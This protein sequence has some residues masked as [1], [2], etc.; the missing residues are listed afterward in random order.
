MTKIIKK[1][2]RTSTVTLAILLTIIGI[3]AV[4]ARTPEFQSYITRQFTGYLSDR[5]GT[6]ISVGKVSYSY[7]NK[8]NIYDVLIEDQNQDTLLSVEHISLR[9][10]ELKPS[11]RQFRFSVA[12]IY[13][14][15][16]RLITDTT[17]MLNLRWYLNLVKSDKERDTTKNILFS[18]PSASLY[19]GS[20]QLINKTDT[21][22]HPAGSVAFNNMKVKGI[23]GSVKE[24]TVRPDSVYFSLIG[25]ILSETTGLEV[26]DADMNVTIRNQD[27]IFRNVR[28]VSESSIINSPQ[29]ALLP[30]DSI[31]FSDFI[32]KVKLDVHLDR[33]LLGTSDLALF[34]PLFRSLDESFYIAGNFSGTV[35]ELNGR[36]VDLEYR[37]STKLRCDFD[38]SGLPVIDNTFA[39]IEVSE[40]RTTADEIE[41]IKIKGK[42]DIAIPKAVHDMGKISFGGNF[43]GFNTDFVA[44]GTIR[45]E[46]GNFSTDISFRPDTTNTFHFEGLLKAR[47]VDMA[48]ITGNPKQPGKLWLHADMDGYSTSLKHF[49]A[50]INGAIDSV[51]FNDYI[52]RNITLQGKVTEKKWDGKVVVDD[53]NIKM[54][55]LGSFD[56]TGLLPKFNFTLDL[57]NSDLY[58]LHLIKGDTLFK[59]SALLTASFEGNNIDNLDGEMRLIK[60]N[61]INSTGEIAIDSLVISSTVEKGVPLITLNSDIIDAEIRGPHNYASISSAIKAELS[62]LFPSKYK[63]PSSK[64]EL[65]K[66]NFAFKVTFE[67]INR[68]NEFLG[69]GIRVEPNSHLYGVFNP[70]SSYITVSFRSG[71]LGAGGTYLSNLTADAMVTGSMLN[72]NIAS[73]T[74]RMPDKSKIMNVAVGLSS[75]PDTIDLGILWDNNDNGNTV[76]EIKAKGFISLN[77][78][79][80]PTLRIEILPTETYVNHIAWQINPSTILIDSVS[81]SFNNILINSNN[82]YFCLDGKV[83]P[84]PGDN[85]TFSFEGLNL[86]Y[87][88]K[89]STRRGTTDDEGEGM[90][91]V[92]GGR[93][94]GN[95]E[96]SDIKKGLRIE[97]DVRINDFTFN[98]SPYGMVS[99]FSEWDSRIKAVRIDIT[100]SFEGARFF[101]IAGTYKPSGNILDL[102]ASLSGMPVNVINP[103]IKSFASDARGLASG[104]I[105]VKGKINQ[106]MLTGGVKAEDASLK[107]DFLKTRYFFND[108]I[109]FTKRGIEFKNIRLL[110]EKKNQGTFNGIIAHNGFKDIYIDLSCN[111]KNFMV[112]NTTSKDADFFYGTAYAT[113]IIGIKGPTNRIAFNISARTENNT[114]FN[115][116]MNSGATMG[117]YP[118]ILFLDSRTSS[119][120]S[121]AQNIM[122]EKKEKKA[123]IDF[124][125]DLEVTPNA[126]VQLIMDS[127]TGDIIKGRGSGNLN[128]GLNPKG[129]IKMAGVYVIGPGSTYLF[130]LGNVIN[131]PFDIKEGGTITWNGGI[132]DAV[133]DLK[134]IY[135][136]RASLNDIWPE[137]EAFRKRIDVEC[138]INLTGKLMNPAVTLGVE[139]PN[140]DDETREYLKMA[141][142][143]DE[144]M[145]RQFLWLLVMNSFYPDPVLYT[146]STVES[147]T[148]GASALGVTTTEMLS[149]QFSNW[150]SQISNDFDIGFAYRPGNDLTPQEVEAAFSTQLLDNRVTFNGNVDV[151][152]KQTN[153][154]AGNITTDFTLEYKLTDKLKFKAFNR[155][156]DDVLYE[157]PPYTQGFG[158]LYRHEFNKIGD[159]LKKKEK[160][161]KK[162]GEKNKKE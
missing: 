35:S 150:L 50:N 26:Y 127:K 113:G 133:L 65:E 138:Q 19:D 156:N 95:I 10:K 58:N 96:V 5:L 40:F 152:G 13:R 46:K 141:V 101:D 53:E 51:G 22:S 104:R 157:K 43:T 132:T 9:I 81:T 86:D 18:I 129:E 37:S 28:L 30:V 137:I 72:I 74:L 128:I 67:E 20:F 103:I 155:A 41:S 80:N 82:N 69:S 63:P 158:I 8:L 78:T 32:N 79:H 90:E 160:S 77:E 34:A 122:F 120:T 135:P 143:T 149:N 76:G 66:N 102:N 159:L 162:E 7:F 12:E 33:S 108:S 106:L 118:Y 57:E 139:A 16:F 85:I 21:S 48:T 131:K 45:T 94:D 61:L 3:T 59:A 42:K 116:P 68:L 111:F 54:D 114:S 24:F 124:N 56:F 29:I 109:R 62:D 83:S 89:I 123:G 15:D 145:T 121:F 2:V 31:G 70:D 107:I 44:Y 110:D 146:A 75:H 144:A 87:L 88:N 125:L 73:D 6:H 4:I 71:F 130:T 93:L 99:V 25:M 52:Y 115:V 38:I 117:E 91:M 119:H 100:N 98:G 126:L 11:S 105:K 92:V 112:L 55:L 134:A 151:G 23:T 161:D 147:T 36:K 27:L 153:T 97:S 17:G 1:I 142:N 14:P 49:A 84:D 47:D 136:T 64:K 60:S 140:A 39:F 154:N 148:Q